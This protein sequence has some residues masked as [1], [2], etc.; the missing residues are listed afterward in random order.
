[1]HS[2]NLNPFQYFYLW[3]GDI[4]DVIRSDRVVFGEHDGGRQRGRK[5]QTRTKTKQRG[6][7]FQVVYWRTDMGLA[8]TWGWLSAKIYDIYIAETTVW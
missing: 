6:Q 4:V 1:M 3:M 7:I 8:D 2:P 5:G